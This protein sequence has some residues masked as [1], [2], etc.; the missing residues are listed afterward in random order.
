MVL[1]TFRYA[2][3][4]KTKKK[5]LVFLCGFSPLKQQQTKSGERWHLYL[6]LFCVPINY[7]APFIWILIRCVDLFYVKTFI[8]HYFLQTFLT[9]CEQSRGVKK[10]TIDFISRT[11]KHFIQFFSFESE[12]FSIFRVFFIASYE[13]VCFFFVVQALHH[14]WTIT[15][16]IFSFS[17]PAYIYNI[18]T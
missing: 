8:F 16:W 15:R 10:K 12:S 9:C 13:I 5:K 1:I 3:Q 7:F 2:E 17:S 6:S 14:K 18:Y 11:L 4:F